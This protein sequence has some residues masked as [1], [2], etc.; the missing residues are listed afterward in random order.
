MAH[1]KTKVQDKWMSM[2]NSN[3]NLLGLWVKPNS[4]YEATCKWC[5][6]SKIIVAYSRIGALMAHSKTKKHKMKASTGT[7][8]SPRAHLNQSRLT[9]MFI[10]RTVPEAANA[11]QSQPV[12]EPMNLK[13]PEPPDHQAKRETPGSMTQFIDVKEHTQKAVVRWA[14]KS[15]SSRYSFISSDHIE[16][17][18]SQIHSLLKLLAWGTRKCHT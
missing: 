16:K 8:V 7:S 1:S 6:G 10:A 2:K 3:G 14:L 11:T 4:D 18:C 13:V 12:P 9:N 5:P 15:A 17:T